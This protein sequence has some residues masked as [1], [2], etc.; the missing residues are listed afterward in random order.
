M[1]N[2]LQKLKNLVLNS[3]E[4]KTL[5]S[6]VVPIIT[7]ILSGTFIIEITMENDLDWMSF[8]KA[9]SF[10]GLLVMVLLIYWYNRIVYQREKTVNRFLD[11]E[12]CVAYMRSE[13]LPEAAERY[14]VLIK[15]GDGG[16]FKQAMDEL[17][18]ILK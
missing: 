18:K 16:E 17:K 10:Y 14:K 9:N 6:V 5:F 2:P 4:L 13:C 11:K 12:Y 1:I 15:N 7:G 8:Y 3:P